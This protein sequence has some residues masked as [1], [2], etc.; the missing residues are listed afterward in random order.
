MTDGVSPCGAKARETPSPSTVK[1][2]D[3]AANEGGGLIELCARTK[4]GNMESGAIQ[5]AQ[6]FLG[7]WLHLKEVQLRK[8]SSNRTQSA[9]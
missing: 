3:H 5:Q 9:R 1:W 7:E 8:A 2:F 6:E 4:F